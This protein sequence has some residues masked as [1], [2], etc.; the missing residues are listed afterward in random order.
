MASEKGL[1]QSLDS[2]GIM[3]DDVKLV[4]EVGRGADIVGQRI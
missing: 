1:W 2:K 4:N 3:N